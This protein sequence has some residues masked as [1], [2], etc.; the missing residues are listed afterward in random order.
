M[1]TWLASPSH[2]CFHPVDAPQGHAFFC[3]LCCLPFLY[4]NGP[5]LLAFSFN[6]PHCLAVARNITW[7]WT[8]WIYLCWSMILTLCDAATITIGALESRKLMDVR[9][10]TFW[11]RFVMYLSWFILDREPIHC[12]MQ[13]NTCTCVCHVVKWPSI[14]GCGPDS[15][16]KSAKWPVNQAPNAFSMLQ[17]Y[18]VVKSLYIVNRKQCVV[19]DPAFCGYCLKLHTYVKV[20]MIVWVKRPTERQ[21]VVRSHPS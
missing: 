20:I 14:P 3:Y 13:P 5:H 19:F 21:Q 15:V 16:W 1:Q 6:H 8:L 17:P 9:D 2:P 10:D 11:T 4:A 7:L 18:A 12:F